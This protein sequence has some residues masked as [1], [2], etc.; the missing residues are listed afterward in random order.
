M[1]Y[2][3]KYLR[4]CDDCL[5]Q[6]R[7]KQFRC[8]HKVAGTNIQCKRQ[9]YIGFSLCY[10]HLAR[11]SHLKIAPA[12][13]PEHGKG[14]FATNLTKD[15]EVVFRKGDR[16][17]E[18]NGDV[19]TKAELDNRYGGDQKDTAPYGFQVN[20]DKYLDSACLRSAGSL[21]NHKPLHQANAKLYLATN[22]G[23]VYIKAL[24]NIKNG[25]EIFVN[26]GR[27]YKF[28]DN[29]ETKYVRK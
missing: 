26:Y 22:N 24:R 27:S 29:H 1:P 12:T 2:V 9:Q 23:C 13:N 5:Y 11:D 20:K 3:F 19:L 18:Y 4:Q 8:E 10:Q 21:A 6:C 28:Q 14:L 25:Q 7:V 15:Q 17:I 16:I